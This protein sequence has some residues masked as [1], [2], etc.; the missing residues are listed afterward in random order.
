VIGAFFAATFPVFTMVVIGYLIT[1]RSDLMRHPGM[2]MLTMQ[3]AMPAL[4]MNS[5]ISKAT[6]LTEML[7]LAGATALCI[8]IGASVV[9]ILCKLIKKP[10]TF[11]ISTLVNP[12]TG[13][14]GIP[15]VFALL[16][17]DALA[18]AVI[19]STA[20][21]LSHFTLGVA[22][23]TGRVNWRRLMI[24][25]PLLSLLIAASIVEVGFVVP[26]P[27][28]RVFE[29]LAGVAQPMMLLL[30]GS[31]LA[32]LSIR[33]RRE[34]GT[35]CM[36][37]LF[38]PISGFLAAFVVAQSLDLEPLLALTLMLQMSMPVAVMSYLLTLKYNGPSQRIAALTISSMPTSLVVLAL[39]YIFQAQLI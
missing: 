14:F 4:I 36:L 34:I 18:A 27:L 21:T 28:M 22:A 30:L 6:P 9:A 3:I 17:A 23:M 24:N 26:A 1:R 13:N 11:Y 39:I 8:L 19:I 35:L 15:L 38:R 25:P 10:A 12:N 29:M 37:S 5:V 20:V 31:S 32:D 7:L 16:G 33:N 2:P